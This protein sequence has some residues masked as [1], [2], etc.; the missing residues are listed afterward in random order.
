MRHPTSRAPL[1]VSLYWFWAW[2]TANHHL[3]YLHACQNLRAKGEP[4]LQN[5]VWCLEDLDKLIRCCDSKHWTCSGPS[6]ARYETLPLTI[7]LSSGNSVWLT[8][9]ETVPALV[10]GGLWLT[11]WLL[12]PQGSKSSCE[13]TV[14]CPYCRCSFVPFLM[15][16]PNSYLQQQDPKIRYLQ[17]FQGYFHFCCVDFF[18]PDSFSLSWMLF[19]F[20]SALTV[21]CFIL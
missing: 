17:D 19:S 14:P 13:L 10:K 7:A 5:S 2:V 16:L 12:L 11:L 4:A 8:W 6:S 9:Y 1:L 21:L 3:Q 15:Q 18:Q 20:K